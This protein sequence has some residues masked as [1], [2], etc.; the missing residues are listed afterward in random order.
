MGPLVSNEEVR[1]LIDAAPTRFIG[2][3]SVAPKAID[4][5]ARLERAF[6][7]LRLSGLK[8]DTARCCLYPY[9][10]QL[11]PLYRL[12]EAYDRPVLFHAGLSMEPG[13]LCKYAHPLEFEEVAARHPRLRMCLAHFGWPWV[14]ETA[15]L[16][17]KY[18]NVYADTAMLYF[19]SAYEFYDRVFRQ[20]LAITWI[21]RSLRH[22]VLFGSD[23]PRFE[24]IR[25]ADALSR[26]GLRDETVDLIKG[27]NAVEF[28]G[29]SL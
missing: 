18:P 6:S 27:T 22:Q 2:F 4:A 16:M 1:A 9:D 12:C 13:G 26:L 11:E 20:E 10:E 25:M 24:Q 14:R 15:A 29:G 5:P 7:E 23:N 21:D 8:L 19:D 28:L 17:L 3:A